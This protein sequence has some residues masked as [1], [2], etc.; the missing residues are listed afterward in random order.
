MGYSGR[1]GPEGVT[2]HGPLV[3]RSDYSVAGDGFKLCPDYGNETTRPPR[4]ETTQPPRYETTQ[5][6]RYETTQPPYTTRGPA[7]EEC[8]SL[9]TDEDGCVSVL[10]HGHN[11]RCTFNM[12][13]VPLR[14]DQFHTE[15][16]CDHLRVNGVEYSGREGPEGVTPHGPLVWRSDYSVAGDGPC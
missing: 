8:S 1:E 14:V 2:P 6:P 11:E 15:E 10:N 12:P 9:V 4:Y 5:R 16:C 3:W 7:P 13:A